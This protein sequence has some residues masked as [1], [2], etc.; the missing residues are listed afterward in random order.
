MQPTKGQDLPQWVVAILPQVFSLLS[1]LGILL[2]GPSR[3]L[4]A[5][6]FVGPFS[7]WANVKTSYGAAGDG[8]T[9]DTAAIQNALNDL[10]AT[11][12]SPILYFP[13]GTYRIS[14]TLNFGQYHQRWLDW[15]GSLDDQPFLGRSIG[16]DHDV[17]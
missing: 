6:E 8:S 9:D 17:Y 16:R 5:E 7:S 13:A 14:Q 4:H 2:Y 15:P 11:G 1:V 3:A 10:G 12:H